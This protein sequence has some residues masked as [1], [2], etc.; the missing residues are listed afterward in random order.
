MLAWPAPI[1]IDCKVR[2][3]PINPRNRSRWPGQACKGACGSLWD[4][5]SVTTILE[6]FSKLVSWLGE[7]ICTVFDMVNEYNVSWFLRK[8]TLP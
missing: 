8:A 1:R 4:I 6:D 7:P 5:Q 3:Q 2:D